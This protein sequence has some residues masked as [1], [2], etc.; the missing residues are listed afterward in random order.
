[1]GAAGAPGRVL[2]PDQGVARA[3]N[4]RGWRPVDRRVERLLGR[5][6]LAEKVAQLA[7]TVD[8]ILGV[9]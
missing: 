4:R 5:M 3:R 2:L 6:T 8:H 7:L 9:R 1:M